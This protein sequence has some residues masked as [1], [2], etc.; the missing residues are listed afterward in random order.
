MILKRWRMFTFWLIPDGVDGKLV[1]YFRAYR[2]SIEIRL[3]R[4]EA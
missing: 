4:R 1:L 2:Y 3:D